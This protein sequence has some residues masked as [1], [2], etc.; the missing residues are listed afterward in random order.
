MEQHKNTINEEIIENKDTKAVEK[1]VETD[2]INYKT[3]ISNNQELLILIVTICIVVFSIFKFAF[4]GTTYSCENYVLSTYLYVL[5]GLIITAFTTMSLIKLDNF[6]K[7]YYKYY[8]PII[9][10][11]IILTIGAS[12]ILHTHKYN[13]AISHLAWLFLCISSGILLTSFIERIINNERNIEKVL[14]NEISVNK[15]IKEEHIKKKNANREKMINMLYKALYT[16]II[17]VIV[18]TLIAYFNLDFFKEHL[19]DNV[20]SVVSIG[21]I[22]TAVI[23]I[24]VWL[25]YTFFTDIKFMHYI[26]DVRVWFSYI[27]ITIFVIMLLYD[28]KNLLSVTKPDCEKALTHCNNT[29]N[30]VN[31]IFNFEENEICEKY[32]NYAVQSIDIYHNIIDI[33]REVIIIFLA[34]QDD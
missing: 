19:T 13:F 9:I 21:F 22:I 11:L 29:Q 7:Y 23:Y 1:P 3:I 12:I 30:K 2:N 26:K 31:S 14:N 25:Y 4:K 34:N 5:L 17:A 28:T 33:F 8:W 27:L 15:L 24:C 32:P 6:R 16:T 20:M 10:V 18:I